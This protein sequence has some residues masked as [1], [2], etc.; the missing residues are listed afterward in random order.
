MI[1]F[2]IIIPS[3]QPK[4]IRI[5]NTKIINNEAIKTKVSQNILKTFPG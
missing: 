1:S 2:E 3:S 4:A 5:V